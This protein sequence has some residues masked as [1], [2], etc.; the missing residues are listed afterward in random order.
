MN[1][2]NLITIC[3]IVLVPFV[4]WAIT[5]DHLL[6]AFWLFIAAGI[7]QKDL[8]EAGGLDA[9]MLEKFLKNAESRPKAALGALIW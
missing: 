3:R 2:P 5:S 4:V 7:H 6:L 9:A 1:L 8:Q